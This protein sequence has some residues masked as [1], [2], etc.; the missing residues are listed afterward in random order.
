MGTQHMGVNNVMEV[1][2]ITSVGKL[3][4]VSRSV[5]RKK[6]TALFVISNIKWEDQ[7]L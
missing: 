1:S 3:V 7:G 5:T 4:T 6:K 2:V